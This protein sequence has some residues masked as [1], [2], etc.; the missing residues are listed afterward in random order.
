[1]FLDVMSAGYAARANAGR[2]R[3]PADDGPDH[4]VDAREAGIG[5]PVP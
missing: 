5:A 1:V 2:Q 3:S 4:P